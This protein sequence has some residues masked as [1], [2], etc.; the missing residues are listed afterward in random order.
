MRAAT[1]MLRRAGRMAAGALPAA[2]LTELGMPAL[3]AVVFLAVTVLAVI[4]WVIAS[5][6]RAN[7]VS[8]M[9]L[10]WRAEASCP[11]EG[12][13]APPVPAS[14]PDTALDAQAGRPDRSVLRMR[15]LSRRP[16]T[17]AGVR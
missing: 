7:R 1:D 9:I 6:D 11:A 3:G 17:T 15:G 8:Q 13:L 4:C 14:A 5:G 16:G 12:T 2:L 10:A